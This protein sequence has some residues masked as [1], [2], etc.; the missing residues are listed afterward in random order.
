M[1]SNLLHATPGLEVACAVPSELGECPVWDTASGRLLWVDIAN[2]RIHRLDPRTG[3][4]ES[5]DVPEEPGCIGLTAAGHPGEDALVVAL[6]SGFH[7]L[8][9]AARALKR[10]SPPLFDTASYRFNDGKV[11]AAG[12][13]WAGAMFEPRTA[14]SASLFTLDHGKASAVAGPAVGFAPADAWG[15]KVSNGL[16]FSPDARTLYQSDTSNHVIYCFDF[17]LAGGAI[18]NRRAWWRTDDRR[19][20]PG[21][22]GR[23]DGAAIDVE[24]CYWSAQ[25]EGGRILRLSPAAEILA[26]IRVPARCP[27]MVCFGGADLRTLF[28]TSAREGRSAAELA[29]W[30]LSGCVFAIDVDTAGMAANRYQA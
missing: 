1:P 24:G 3:P 16:A 10:L 9:L 27:T 26:E 2:R 18:E 20:A 25:Y 28:I 13:F 12:R 11:D 30:P 7:H 29:Q 5:W 8:D 6:R 23:P 19:T 21:Y 17:E 4:L 14:A 15:V 22:G